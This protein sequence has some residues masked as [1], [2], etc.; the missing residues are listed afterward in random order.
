MAKVCQLFSGSSGNAIYIENAGHSILVDIG[1][2]AKRCEGALRQIGVDP[3]SIRAVVITH[4][5]VDHVRGLRVFCSRYG[6]NV[7]APSKCLQYLEAHGQLSVQF[8]ARPSDLPFD[9][10]CFHF[11]PFRLSHDSADC[12]G[13]RIDLQNGTGVAVCTD[14]GYV[15]DEARAAIA[16][17]D[18][19]FL[20]SNHEVDMLKSGPYPYYLKQRILSDRGH[21]S[22]GD[23]AAFAAELVGSGTTRVVLAHLSR[24]NNMPELARS[25]AFASFEKIG[26][27]SGSDYRLYVSAPENTER[28]IVL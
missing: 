3:A 6:T 22:N 9:D 13:Y 27:H 20:E 21:L 18:L 8:D 16:G 7:Y 5:H 1:V 10:G 26:A 11:T 4:E 23:S 15:P 14:T 25:A 12:F 17:S 24:E 19:V 28:P 2:S